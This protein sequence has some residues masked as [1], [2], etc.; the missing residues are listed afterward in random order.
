MKAKSSSE[1]IALYPGSFDP[2]TNGHLEIITRAATLFD[3]VIV[4]VSNNSAKK[5]Y[6]FTGEER[7][8]LVSKACKHLK[9]VA[10]DYSDGLI[11]DYFKARNCSVIVKGLRA[12]SDFESEF[13]MAHINKQL[14]SKAETIF[15]CSEVN[16]TYLSSSLV[17][18]ISMR[19]GDISPF[20]PD[21]ILHYIQAKIQ[22]RSLGK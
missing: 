12:V 1:K 21:N 19:G 5:E 6:M 17:K 4:L 18:E 13:Q 22:R 3:R 7:V 2:I 11:A 15:L 10:V 16:N 20:V 8:M 9:N 14:Y